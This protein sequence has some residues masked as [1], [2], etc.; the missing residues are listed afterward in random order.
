MLPS[1]CLTHNRPMNPRDEVSRPG[2]DFNGEPA[3]PEDGRLVPHNRHRIGVWM[4]GSFINQR[5]RSNEE[6]K[7]KGRIQRERQWAGKAKRIFSLA[8][9]LQKDQPLVGVG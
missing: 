7:S 2:R 8:Q 9:H 6:P 4:P 1:L 3:D 5:E